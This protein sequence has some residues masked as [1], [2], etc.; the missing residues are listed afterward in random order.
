MWNE[1]FNV[2]DMEILEEEFLFPEKENEKKKKPS[3]KGS[4][5]D[6]FK[7]FIPSKETVQDSKEINEMKESLTN[8][9][10]KQAYDLLEITIFPV[11]YEE[12][13][14]AYYMQELT[15]QED[16]EKLQLLKRARKLIHDNISI[17]PFEDGEFI[18]EHETTEAEEE[19]PFLKE[20]VVDAMVN[21]IP[22]KKMVFPR[23][24][25]FKKK[26]K[27]ESQLK[28]DDVEKEINNTPKSTS[29]Q[30]KAKQKK[31]LHTTKKHIFKFLFMSVIILG[32]IYVIYSSEQSSST[33]DGINISKD[34]STTVEEELYMENE[35]TKENEISLEKSI[36]LLEID[37][38]K[39]D[40]E[41]V[42]FNREEL[43]DYSCVQMIRIPITNISLIKREFTANKRYI[44]YRVCDYSLYKYKGTNEPENTW[45]Q[46]FNHA[47]CEVIE[48]DLNG[49]WT[50]ECTTGKG[51][52]N[53]SDVVLKINATE[54]GYLKA[55]FQFISELNLPGKILMEGTYDK[56]KNQFILQGEEWV[57]R[58]KLFVAPQLSGKIDLDEQKLTHTYKSTKTTFNLT[59]TKTASENNGISKN[60]I[61]SLLKERFATYEKWNIPLKT[62]KDC[63]ILNTEK[64]AEDEM[65]VSIVANVSQ[66]IVDYNIK[67]DIVIRK[68]NGIWT[69]KES[70][71]N[72]IPCKE[73]ISGQYNGSETIGKQTYRLEA[74]VKKETADSYTAIISRHYY[75]I[76]IPFSVEEWN[77]TK[78]NDSIVCERSDV[79]KGTIKGDPKQYLSINHDK[80]ILENNNIS[81]KKQQ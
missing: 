53:L 45:K 33:K 36:Q 57:E 35:N 12:V 30:Q 74:D 49:T 40:K 46:V 31:S 59:S 14:M 18:T 81:L 65:R 10:L 68:R 47:M 77:I 70:R 55:E 8:L 64:K 72:A 39:I 76:P 48:Y 78:V 71:L 60:T 54:N 73:D 11:S 21:E 41:Q 25:I 19:I 28:W 9:S 66:D 52:Y 51:K 75:F 50:G 56:K 17:N 20:P 69:M 43:T 24:N 27:S 23:I 4:P 61:R 42:H 37:G 5:F 3:F 15:L 26:R 38:L 22:A 80:D 13:R 29:H 32:F 79:L 16:E 1:D 58:P 2:D 67:G 6:F 63:S 34:T 62:I 7:K 44:T